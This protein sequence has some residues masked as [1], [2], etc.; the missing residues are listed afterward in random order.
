MAMQRWGLKLVDF[1]QSIR[2]KKNKVDNNLFVVN[3]GYVE[4]CQCSQHW[5]GLSSTRLLHLFKRP[6]VGMEVLQSLF[7]LIPSL[8][9]WHNGHHLAC[10]TCHVPPI[11]SHL[12]RVIC[13]MNFFVG[14][15]RWKVCYQQG[16]PS[17]VSYAILNS[18]IYIC[19]Q[20]S[21][22]TKPY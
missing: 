14:A 15:S 9:F 7:K 22:Q 4:L 3:H 21:K 5:K 18:Q 17:L 10:V 20:F 13:H 2:Q 6:S 16:L 11:T 12:S 1:S 19:F 8:R